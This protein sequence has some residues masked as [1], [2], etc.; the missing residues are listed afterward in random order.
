MDIQK[1][2]LK[3]LI[4]TVQYNCHIADA[5]HAGDYTLC[6]YLLKMREMYRWEQ[7]ID[8]KTMLTTDDVGDWLTEREGLWDD[9]EELQYKPLSIKGKN[10]DPFD[11]DLINTLL[12]E[13]MYNKKLVY[14]AGL[15]IRC[16]P[17][18]F[19]ADLEEKIE[20]DNYTVYISGEEYA[21][22]MAAPASMAQE[23][24]IFIRRES[25]R[26]VIWEILDDA[27]VNGL[28][29]PLTRAMSYY[30]FDTDA[31]VALN[32]MAEAEIDFVIQHEV[33]EVKAGYILG[34]G[35]NDM[36]SSLARTQAEIML[37]A[38]RDHLADSIMTLPA[39]LDGNKPASLHFYFGNM[40]AMRKH[41]APA[42]MKAYEYWY[43]TDDLSQLQKLAKQSQSHWQKVAEGVTALFDKSPE[44]EPIETFIS[45]KKQ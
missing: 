13:E 40:T 37:R 1:N 9:V 38:I 39:L 24:R 12:N 6:V 35:W 43:E 29:N 22:D 11:N 19:I 20:Q 18:F 4:E 44:A 15:G 7:S 16:R 2:E 3:Q 8:F 21:R 41:L 17:H 25:L 36:L 45:S 10:Y 34:E 5:R 30:D 31:E 23:H 26:R 27:R 32:N 14:N 28:D 42:L 33:G